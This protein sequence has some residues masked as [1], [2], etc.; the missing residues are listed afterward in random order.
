MSELIHRDFLMDLINACRRLTYHR[1]YGPAHEIGFAIVDIAITAAALGYH[2][3]KD[4]L[5]A[6]EWAGP[7]SGESDEEAAAWRLKSRQSATSDG[8]RRTA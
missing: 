7:L 2:D 8:E 5:P 6:A 1:K 4:T 3:T